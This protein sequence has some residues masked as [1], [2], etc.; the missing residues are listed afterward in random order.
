MEAALVDSPMT[1][2]PV[3]ESDNFEFLRRQA[4]AEGVI[5]FQIPIGLPEVQNTDGMVVRPID[6]R[7][8]PGGL[9]Y[10]GQLRGR[11]LPVAVARFADQIT[12][13]LQLRFE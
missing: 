12:K 10:V 5:S 9:I 2:D 6:P 7:D 8:V 4:A 11:T 3:I 1:L 13:A